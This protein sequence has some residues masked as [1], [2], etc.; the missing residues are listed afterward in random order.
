MS[1]S[2]GW[3]Y[4]INGKEVSQE[5]FE[6]NGAEWTADYE[7]NEYQLSNNPDSDKIFSEIEDTKKELHME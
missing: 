3:I 1:Q 7:L 6:Q 5:E 4:E 2:G